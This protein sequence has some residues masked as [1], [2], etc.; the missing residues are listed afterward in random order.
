MFQYN[1]P[2]AEIHGFVDGREALKWAELN[3]VDI[4]F[5]QFTPES[6]EV[7]GV[8]GAVVADSLYIDGKC[9]NFILCGESLSFSLD[10]WNCGASFFYLKPVTN[11]KIH[12]G[13]QHLR[14][15]LDPIG[16]MN[17]SPGRIENHL[18]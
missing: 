18:F 3:R 12:M 2:N 11:K 1:L 15:P 9:K 10:A 7:V 13:L 6:E 4:V 17:D 16:I 8:E 5:A 14:Y